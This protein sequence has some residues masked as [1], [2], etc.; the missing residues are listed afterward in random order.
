MEGKSHLRRLIAPL[1]RLHAGVNPK[2]VYSRPKN[3]HGHGCLVAWAICAPVRAHNTHTHTHTHV[4]TV[5][6][7][8]YTTI[9]IIAEKDFLVSGELHGIHTGNV[10][11]AL[12]Y[13]S[14][15]ARVS[16]SVVQVV[17]TWAEKAV[18]RNHLESGKG[19]AAATCNNN[20]NGI[21]GILIGS[22]PTR[23]LHFLLI[24]LVYA[25][26]CFYFYFSLF[27]V[28]LINIIV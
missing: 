9:P 22:R 5:C 15:T 13:D 12:Q 7:S 2:A 8:L 21:I 19:S 17:D 25:G 14:R 24:S 4:H 3:W 18:C 16:L 6:K 23:S 11:A 27:H 10:P 28:I 1:R 20:N 26:F